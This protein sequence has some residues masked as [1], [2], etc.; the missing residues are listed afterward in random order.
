MMV[1]EKTWPGLR[2]GRVDV[3]Q[4]MQEKELFE[5][6][7]SPIGSNKETHGR[8]CSGSENHGFPT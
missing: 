2:A 3:L 6:N 4:S 1:T 7:K 5:A 8:S